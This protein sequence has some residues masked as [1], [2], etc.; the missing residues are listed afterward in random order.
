MNKITLDNLIKNSML[1]VPEGT[2]YN[3]WSFKDRATCKDWAVPGVYQIME[4]TTCI[5]VGISSNLGNRLHNHISYMGHSTLLYKVTTE[6]KP[7]SYLH[8]LSVR[9]FQE[10]ND[11]YRNIYEMYLIAQHH[12]PRYNIWGTGAS[13][14]VQ[15]STGRKGASYPQEVVEAV[16]KGYQDC[17]PVAKLSELHQVS[18]SM[19]YKWAKRYSWTRNYSKSKGSKVAG[20]LSS[21]H[22]ELTQDYLAGMGINEM[23]D[24]YSTTKDSLWD[25]MG[26]AGIKRGSKEYHKS[27]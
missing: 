18:S 7:A 25:Y 15:D 22:Q 13:K 20:K 19:I 6:G 9:V 10:D 1:Q 17:T 2:E 21:R 12:N 26:R 27:I 5:Y 4:G 8:G 11:A 3:L 14:T 23:A 16:H 24:K